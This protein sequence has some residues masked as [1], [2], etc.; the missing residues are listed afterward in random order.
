MQVAKRSEGFG[1]SV[2]GTQ[3]SVNSEQGNQ[4]LAE[5]IR[6]NT[7]Y[8][9]VKV[10]CGEG[11]C[12]ACTVAIVQTSADG[13]TKLK[14]VNSCLTP[15]YAVDGCQIVTAEG[16]P[17][18]PNGTPVVAERFS[19][20][21][22][23]QCGFCTP[24]FAVACHAQ[25]H[26]ACS[27][28]AGA[29]CTPS[30]EAK[31]LR[32][33]LDGNLCRCTG[34]RPIV[35]VCKSF[36]SDVD[37]EDLGMHVSWSTPITELPS[38][39]ILVAAAPQQGLASHPVDEEPPAYVLGP[40]QSLAV[41]R[42]LDQL[43]VL[44]GQAAKGGADGGVRLVAGHTGP[45][46]YKDWPRQ[47]RLVSITKVPELQ[48]IEQADGVLLLGACVTITRLIEYLEALATATKPATSPLVAAWATEIASHLERIAGRHVRNSATLGGNLALVRTRELPSDVVTPLAAAG[49]TVE[50]YDFSTLD[51]SPLKPTT[52]PILDFV[53]GGG[54]SSSSGLLVT[55][56]RV[57]LPAEGT[58]FWS[59]RIAQRYSNAAALLNLSISLHAVGC[60]TA[61]ARVVLGMQRKSNHEGWKVF[62]CK[63]VEAAVAGTAAAWPATV[64]ALQALSADLA[65]ESLADPVLCQQAEGL[66]YQGLCAVLGLGAAGGANGDANGH[67]AQ[68][69]ANGHENGDAN[70]H[71]PS[72][73]A[74]AK[75]A[76]PPVGKGTQ[77]F[78]APT[79]ELLPL[80]EPK[81]K[82]R[83]ELQAMGT[84]QYADDSTI[85]RDALFAAWV[86]SDRGNADIVSVDAA[87]AL[88][89]PGVSHFISAK[90]VPAG[91][92]NQGVWMFPPALTPCEPIFADTR[93]EYAG[94]PLGLVLA[95]TPSTAQAA[96]K[97][98]AVEYNASPPVLSVADAV[99][100]GNFY[101]LMYSI[102]MPPGPNFGGNSAFKEVGD[103]DKALAES[104]HTVRNARYVIPSQQHFYMEPQT[105]VA[106][107]DE[108]G[109]MTVMSSCQGTDGIQG[110]VAG[111]LGVPWQKVHARCRRVGGGFGGK[112]T[113][114]QM[115][116]TAVSVAAA[117]TGHQVRLA[118]N[119]NVDMAMNGG[120]CYTETE[121]SVGFDS[122]G[123]IT[124][125]DIKVYL[126]SGAYM[127]CSCFDA[128]SVMGAIDSVY[129]IPNMRVEAVLLRTHVAPRT[130]VRGP[131]EIQGILGIEVVMEHV[132]AEL[133]LA[134]E[135]VRERNFL[136]EK[137]PVAE[138]EEEALMHSTLGKH[139]LPST[140]TL[141]R[142]WR[143]LKV[144][145][146][147]DARKAAVE[148]FNRDNV[149]RK[150]GISM[151]PTRYNFG[152]ARRP[153]YVSIYQ[154]GS[155][156]V[157]TFGIEMGQGL[158]TKVLQTAAYELGKILP[159]GGPPLPAGM[160]RFADN[161]TE[162]LPNGGFTGGSTG[163]ETSCTAVRAACE[164]LGQQMKGAAE[165][166]GESY[167]W[168]ELVNACFGI[169]LTGCGSSTPLSA[170]A[171]AGEYVPG[172]TNMFGM[173]DYATFGTGVTEVEID[174]LTGE[175]RVL[176]TDIHFDC[177]RS[178][179]P[180]VDIGQVEGAFVQGLGMMLSEEVHADPATGLLLNNSTWNYKVPGVGCIPAQINISLLENSPLVVK[181]PIGSKAIGE[182]PLLLSAT[183]LFAL[184]HATQAAKAQL[185]Q[186]AAG[187]DKAAK[188]AFT[189]LI[190]P[191]TVE[192]VREACG[193]WSVAEVVKRGVVV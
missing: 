48:T 110:S 140:Y 55:Q 20:F 121:Y 192:K 180:A 184:H 156:L 71:A 57:P 36:A 85:A 40:G 18:G 173:S 37:M 174:V 165:K 120:R 50:V 64:A 3:F 166:L 134:P 104:A 175:R 160:L 136:A 59:S 155:V 95:D 16:L 161:S 178:L 153:A 187:Q 115:C 98:V 181:S 45:G 74:A 164:K 183:G 125:L 39:S 81:P 112:F 52:Y 10:G 44:M 151:M 80:T 172:P 70:G 170:H 69:G 99:A 51:G 25:L 58:H 8:K 5:W 65:A 158:A 31:Q 89:M 60:A 15:V 21:H 111:V 88:A 176:R 96:A 152:I 27:A 86:V 177:G 124:A 159:G 1:V 92:I 131:G 139:F 4:N 113:R 169:P 94:Q 9:S 109:G 66:L 190:A 79:P 186:P 28:A 185:Q 19:S 163:S 145:A 130:S 22:A 30:V 77:S 127:D 142:L 147:F 33:G 122:E 129:H 90:D 162:L 118:T 53:S 83:A 105:A 11:G 116:A 148:Q 167:T 182:P 12:G 146:D 154:D 63:G 119:R 189:P 17:K 101:N 188:V 143:E 157:A 75:M 72:V 46:V 84:A 43:V 128:L 41:P 137:V 34:Y 87:P 7:T 38:E 73:P 107:P 24:G 13:T 61:E 42:S 149:W 56:L 114:G 133:G 54:P 193:E 171:F 144:K 26:N 132:A 2:N 106:T 93:A 68:D 23:S 62:R 126:V 123:K 29:G 108:D 191:A 76:A 49:A 138:G 117:A 32:D 168:L 150:R 47:G 78:P 14:T 35:D 67:T 82:W 103:V 6:C 102:G 97:A 100:A 179:N 135:V 91:G 141:H